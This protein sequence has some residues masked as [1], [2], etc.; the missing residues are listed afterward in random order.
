MRKRSLFFFD[1]LE[2]PNQTAEAI[3]TALLACLRS[4]GL[5]EDYLKENLI[6]IVCDGAS[7]MLGKKTG[8]AARLREIVSE[9]IVWH[10]MSHRVELAVHDTMEDI[11]AI[12]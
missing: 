2:L 7:V 6:C 11:T 1:L 4:Y 9:V 3:V 12:N 5:T 10:C 8:V